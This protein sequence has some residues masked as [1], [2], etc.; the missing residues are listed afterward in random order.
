MPH[1]SRASVA[2]LS[3]LWLIAGIAALGMGL[4]LYGLLMAYHGS[5]TAINDR[6]RLLYPAERRTHA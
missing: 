2:T 3:P 5:A 6:L 4:L 1:P